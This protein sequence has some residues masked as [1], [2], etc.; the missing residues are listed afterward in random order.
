MAALEYVHLRPGDIPPSLD[1]AA[2]FR[3]IVV[4]DAYVTREWQ[5]QV[6]DWLVRAGCRY[7]MAW[8]KDCSAWDD[9][10]DLA[11]LEKFDF[12]EIPQD[13]FVMTTW[14]AD[15]TLDEAFWFSQFCAMHPS[16]ELEKTYIVHISPE[17]REATMLQTFA[18]AQEID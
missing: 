12:G 16:L 17:E 1:D 9:S 3:A 6:S 7:M 11:V 14:H 15:D 2:P 4:I 5:H 13:D 18:A 8:G 10:V